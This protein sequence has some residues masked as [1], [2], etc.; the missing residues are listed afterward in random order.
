MYVQAAEIPLDSSQSLSPSSPLPRLHIEY[1]RA[2]IC[3]LQER[4]AEHAEEIFE[5]LDKGAHMYFC[6]LKGMMPGI[7][8]TLEV[9]TINSC[10]CCFIKCLFS[11]IGLLLLSGGRRIERHFV[12]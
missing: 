4:L 2:L 7:L 12:D 9:L 8:E 6:G 5:R 10:P 1:L 3:A 11:I